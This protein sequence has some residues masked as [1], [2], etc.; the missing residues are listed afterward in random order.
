MRSFGG[1]SRRGPTTQSSGVL[2]EIEGK[3][4]SPA[5]RLAGACM[6]EELIAG[7]LRQRLII[8]PAVG[9]VWVVSSFLTRIPIEELYSLFAGGSGDKSLPP[10]PR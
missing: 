7:V 9:P 6:L 8:L 2:S 1:W 3:R 10:S 5:L 4:F